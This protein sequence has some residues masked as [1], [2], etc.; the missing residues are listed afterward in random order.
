MNIVNYYHRFIHLSNANR[1]NKYTLNAEEELEE[2]EN[3]CELS[4]KKILEF[5]RVEFVF[6]NAWIK[7]LEH[8]MLLREIVGSIMERF[9]EDLTILTTF[10]KNN[11]ELVLQKTV[12]H[13]LV[14]QINQAYEKL[15]L[16]NKEMKKIT[17]IAKLYNLK[18]DFPSYEID[19]KLNR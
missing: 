19:I 17:K 16:I 3:F 12:R 7:C 9:R 10:V 2:A 4:V 15:I 6:S 18:E 8:R 14:F 11:I 5:I 1:Y 13:P